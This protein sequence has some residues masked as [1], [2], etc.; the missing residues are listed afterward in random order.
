MDYWEFFVLVEGKQIHVAGGIV[1]RCWYQVSW[2]TVRIGRLSAPAS[3]ESVCV[4][5]GWYQFELG[6][7]QL[8][9]WPSETH[10][11]G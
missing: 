9:V 3:L 6:D 7:G 10:G 8:T 5:N 11:D 4:G 2:D 1:K